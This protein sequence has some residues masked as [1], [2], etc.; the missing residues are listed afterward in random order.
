FSMESVA[1]LAD[2]IGYYQIM[3]GSWRHGDR[4]LATLKRVTPADVRTVASTWKLDNDAVTTWLLPKQRGPGPEPELRA[5][6]V[7]ALA[8]ETVELDNG[9]RL[10]MLPM[11]SGPEVFTM[12][13]RYD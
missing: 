11:T 10:L 1:G 8:V 2:K 4:E 12:R 13:V 3:N 5:P 7:E 6:T 9:L